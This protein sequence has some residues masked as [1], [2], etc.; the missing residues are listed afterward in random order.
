[1]G[2]KDAKARRLLTWWLPSEKA[3]DGLALII[4]PVNNR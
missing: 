2:I 4:V 3:E 1:M